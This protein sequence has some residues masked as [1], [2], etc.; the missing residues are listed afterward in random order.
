MAEHLAKEGFDV[1]ATYTLLYNDS[2]LVES[3][4]GVAVCLDDIVATGEGTPFSSVPLSNAPPTPA[5]LVWRRFVPLSRACELFYAPCAT[6]WPQANSEDGFRKLLM[7]TLIFMY[8]F[9]A[10]W[11][12]K[13]RHQGAQS[14]AQTRP[15]DN[16]RADWTLSVTWSESGRIKSDQVTF[17]HRLGRFASLGRVQGGLWLDATGQQ[18]PSMRTTA[19][20]PLPHSLGKRH[21]VVA[22]LGDDRP[23]LLLVERRL[24][25]DHAG[26]FSTVALYAL[27]FEILSNGIVNVH[28]AHGASH[29]FDTECRFDHDRIP[30]LRSISAS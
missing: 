13:A 21:E 22:K 2:L 3:G 14:L 10:F 25:N 12:R 20:A 11:R 26:L 23:Y 18:S 30:D 15:S 27:Y 6:R 8:L 7:K 29:A 28:F 19:L 5:Y 1:A 24:R 9:Q 16:L 4:M 17:C